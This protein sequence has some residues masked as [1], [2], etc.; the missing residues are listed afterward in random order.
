MG[1]LIWLTQHFF[2]LG[3][4]NT[5]T[6]GVAVLVGL[7][8]TSLW[9]VVCMTGSSLLERDI[10]RDPVSKQPVP[11]VARE[12]AQIWAAFFSRWQLVRSK[13]K[14]IITRDLCVL[15]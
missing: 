6:I 1:D 9:Q 7:F 8:V 12:V 14:R 13:G 11:Q 5:Q 4:L 10:H 3:E 15:W 2:R